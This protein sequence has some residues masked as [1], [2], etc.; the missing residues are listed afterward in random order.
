MTDL[1]A[2]PNIL[3]WSGEYFDLLNPEPSRINIRDVASA[4]SK[5]CRFTGH[6]HTFYSVA[7]HSVL[8]SRL[9]P[10]EHALAGLLHDA[11]EAFI[12]D[13]SSPLKRLLPDYVA[14][15]E[16]V[17]AAVAARFGLPSP[18]P[19]CIKRADLV[20]LA[21]EARDLLPEPCG[22]GGHC[23]EGAVNGWELLQGVAP[24]PE[25]ILPWGPTTARFMF[26]GR[27]KELAREALGQ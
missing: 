20:M 8:V 12:G 23:S 1:Q 27:Y 25:R 2:P 18:L 19:E 13:V 15:E 5:I 14:V 16:R 24:T 7:Q 17:E 4:L 22:D 11:A 6:T 21:T 3:L 26:L 9:V 10:P